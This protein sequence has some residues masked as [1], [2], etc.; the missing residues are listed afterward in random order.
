MECEFKVEFC[1]AME[2]VAFDTVVSQTVLISFFLPH[3][4]IEFFSLPYTCLL[5]FILMYDLS[6][7]LYVSL[8]L[9]LCLLKCTAGSH[10]KLSILTHWP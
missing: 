8:G 3:A 4:V 2:K 1:D 6:C 5:L 10:C 9:W 7:A